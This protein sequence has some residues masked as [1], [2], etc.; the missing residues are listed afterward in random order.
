MIA[1]FVK[2][3]P[4]AYAFT[5]LGQRRYL[6]LL[7]VADVMVGNSS[8]G[9]IEAPSFQLPVVNI[10]DRQQGRVRAANVIDCGVEQ[11]EIAIALDQ[12]LSREFRE[13][14]KDLINPCGTGQASSR[15]V[16]VLKNIRLDEELIK[17]RFKDLTCAQY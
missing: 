11:H 3:E 12:A 14:L 17:K 6:G 9:I 1:D 16:D 15:I 4:N 7:S 8:S 5:S 13:S 2:K 10:G